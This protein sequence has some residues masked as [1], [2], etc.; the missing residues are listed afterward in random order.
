[1]AD[2]A[3]LLLAID[4]TQVTPAASKLDSLTAAGERA[5][6]ATTNLNTSTTKLRDAYIMAGGSAAE[7]DKIFGKVGATTTTTASATSLLNKA[8]AENATITS[9]MVT[10]AAVEAK[11]ILAQA[12]AAAEAS[13]VQIAANE[14]V[15]ASAVESAA[16]QVAATETIGIKSRAV[17]ESLVIIREIARGNW[18]RLAGSAS[19]LVQQFVAIT[20]TMFALAA[21]V[22]VLLSP[23]IALGLA[24]ERGREQS[25][26]F[27]EGVIST[28]NFAG[29]TSSQFENMA[30]TISNSNDQSVRSNMSVIST[31][32][33]GGKYSADTIALITDA[34]G[35]LAHMTGQTQEEVAKSF[36]N[37]KSSVIKFAVTHEQTYH[38]LTFQQLVYIDNLEKQGKHELAEYELAKDID[39]ATT[40]RAKEATA[41]ELANQG[42]LITGWKSVEK[43]ASSAWDA[44]MG[45]GRD[46]TSAEKITSDLK[47]IA[48]AQ[49]TINNPTSSFFLT[50]EEN[51]TAAISKLRGASGT[52]QSNRFSESIA[53]RAR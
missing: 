26:K 23:L 8:L 20:A 2:L 49:S 16:V 48:D 31:L 9:G 38:D 18:S 1:M 51:K 12:A 42:Y 39:T 13:A 10:A 33:A 21:G 15:A 7:A 4:A 46:Q 53:S 22:A 27:N 47:V 29:I 28:G 6:A 17:S 11:S 36:E 35:K 5:E 50:A 52:R 14:A 25:K 45:W 37:M 3:N 32:I 30:K 19:I 43:A 41:K 44:M 24:M 34:S 40:L